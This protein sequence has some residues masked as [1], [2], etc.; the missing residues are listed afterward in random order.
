MR[1]QLGAT[2][3][4]A[5][6]L[7]AITFLAVCSDPS[8]PPPIDAPAFKKVVTPQDALLKSLHKATARFHSKTQ[9]SKAGY[10]DTE[11]CVAVPGLGGMGVH[12]VNDALVDPVFDPLHPEALLY[13]PGPN[14]QEKLVGV[15]YIVIDVGQEAPT[16]AG[17]AFDVGGSPVPVDHWTLH[18]WLWKDNPAGLFMPFNPNVVCP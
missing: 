6:A 8:V 7:L 16:F 15:E 18:V 13:E 3:R 4:V 17:Q 1:H 14:G 10:V 11:E 9:A 5:L 12:W 2:R